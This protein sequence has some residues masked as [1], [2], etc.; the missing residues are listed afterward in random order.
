M[1][2]QNRLLARKNRVRAVISG[3]MMRPRLSVF[4]SNVHAYAQAIDDEGRKTLVSSHSMKDKVV[5]KEICE[6]MAKDLAGKLKK[7]GIEKIVFD[8]NGRKYHG[9]IHTIAETLRSEGI[10]F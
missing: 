8:R 6:K 1:D 7:A 10:V 2:K 5:N 4:I 3:T 9:K